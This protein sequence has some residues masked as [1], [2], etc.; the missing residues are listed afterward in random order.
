MTIHTFLRGGLGNQFFIYACAR[1][2]SLKTKSELSIDTKSFFVKDK[3]SRQSYLEKT[4]AIFKPKIKIFS[5]LIARMSSIFPE[6]DKILRHLGF[7]FQTSKPFIFSKIE[8]NRKN[9]VSMFGY[10]QNELYFKPFKNIIKNELTPKIKLSG[11]SKK[12]LNNIKTT[13]SI[14]LH[15]RRNHNVNSKGEIVSERN[16]WILP[17]TYYEKAIPLI[18]ALVQKPRFFIF[19]DQFEHM[20]FYK[21]IKHCSSIVKIARKNKD[22]DYEEFYLMNQCKHFII[23]NSTFSWWAAWL[24]KDNNKIVISPDP[25]QVFGA[26]AVPKTWK[27]LKI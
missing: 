12:I 5:F 4:N 8:L 20:S 21:K 10:W 11:Q 27:V 1:A 15:L 13:N 7:F 24:N 23:S 6:T 9:N 26:A 14:C 16:K 18:S 25:Y 3:F 19:A 2:I 17:N 22:S